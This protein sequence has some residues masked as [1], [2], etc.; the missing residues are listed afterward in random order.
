[1]PARW[2]VH[3][4]TRQTPIHNLFVMSADSLSFP[5]WPFLILLLLISVGALPYLS[6][7][8][9]LAKRF[10]VWA[11]ADGQRF[12]FVSA[13]VGKYSWFRVNFGASLS[14]IVGPGGFQVSSLFPLCPALFVPWSEVESV[15][16]RS[17]ALSRRTVVRFRGSPVVFAFRGAVG[18]VVAATYADAKRAAA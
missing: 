12:Y 13:K 16:D 9:S 18:Q 17:S 4:I 7:W 6:G 11:P 1:M 3:L 15:E 2:R 14:L 5:F 10:P 8:R